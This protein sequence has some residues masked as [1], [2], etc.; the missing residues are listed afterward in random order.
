MRIVL[1]MSG[2]EPK[3]ASSEE[4]WHCQTGRLLTTLLGF[5]LL[6]A[7][8][9]TTLHSASKPHDY[10]SLC[11]SSC[12]HFPKVPLSSYPQ[13]FQP[14]FLRNILHLPLSAP[15]QIV[16]CSCLFNEFPFHV[17]ARPGKEWRLLKFPTYLCRVNVLLVFNSV[18]SCLL[19]SQSDQT[20]SFHFF[21]STW[22][23]L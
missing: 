16:T 23:V 8:L 10:F 1:L 22:L 4:I 15:F 11:M 9:A 14:H 12:H 17:R 3:N 19:R 5:V 21:T 20:L 2:W 6:Q 7:H 13:A 18:S